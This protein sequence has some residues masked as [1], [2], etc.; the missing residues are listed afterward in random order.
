MDEMPSKAC[1]NSRGYSDSELPSCRASGTNQYQI[2]NFAA[3]VPNDLAA[4][5]TQTTTMHLLPPFVK[6][7]QNLQL[8]SFTALGISS[9]VPEALLTPPD[10]TIIH[11][12]MKTPPPTSFP[13]ASRRS[14]YPAA[15]TPKTPSPDRS[16]FVSVLDHVVTVSEASKTST[17]NHST[18]AVS[19]A[20]AANAEH[21]TDPARSDSESSDGLPGQFDW[22]MEAT[23]VLGELHEI[24]ANHSVP[25]ADHCS[26]QPRCRCYILCRVHALPYPTLSSHEYRGQ[27]ERREQAPNFHR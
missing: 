16:D 3:P 11:D 9:R 20:Q 2:C 25:L 23:D 13:S 15:N 6:G 12:F 14:S 7:R 24:I 18:L 17:S 10:E 27:A 4:A 5:A 21:G 1:L 8:P 22:L 26:C 19:E